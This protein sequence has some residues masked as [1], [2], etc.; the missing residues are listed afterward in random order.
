MS[1]TPFPKSYPAIHFWYS[2][3]FL[4]WSKDYYLEESR[5]HTILTCFFFFVP[6]VSDSFLHKSTGFFFYLSLRPFFHP[7][8]NSIKVYGGGVWR[9]IYLRTKLSCSS[10]TETTSR[11]ELTTFDSKI[12][13]WILSRSCRPFVKKNPTIMTLQA[14]KKAGPRPTPSRDWK[15]KGG[16]QVSRSIHKINLVFFH[17]K[18]MMSIQVN[19]NW[20]NFLTILNWE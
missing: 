7:R 15:K 10:A 1:N 16:Y 17:S 14:W 11:A 6:I 19:K 4:D 3:Y 2:I 5:S 12:E 18:Y 9:V 8:K 13:G 20:R